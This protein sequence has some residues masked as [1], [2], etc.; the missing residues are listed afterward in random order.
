MQTW[1]VSPVWHTVE[2]EGVGSEELRVYFGVSDD[3]V[4][5]LRLCYLAQLGVEMEDLGR[6]REGT[7]VRPTGSREAT[8]SARACRTGCPALR[9]A[10]ANSRLVCAGRPHDRAWS[11]HGRR[12][13]A[14]LMQ[15]MTLAS[16]SVAL[17]YLPQKPK[18]SSRAKRSDPDMMLT[19][20]Q[21]QG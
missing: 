20:G 5:L 15:P 19:C 21:E 13:R 3:D 6:K 18:R 16:R 4:S 14:R 10:S 17:R 8:F 9:P 2:V 12:T 7:C 1:L 11:R